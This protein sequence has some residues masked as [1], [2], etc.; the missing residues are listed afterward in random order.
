MTEK[1]ENQAEVEAICQRIENLIS[2]D[3]LTGEQKL[4]FAREALKIIDNCQ[5]LKEVK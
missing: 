1:H 4:T 2:A 3:H 5:D